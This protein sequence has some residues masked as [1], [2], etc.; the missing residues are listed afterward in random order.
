MASNGQR[1]TLEEID[2]KEGLDGLAAKSQCQRD[3]EAADISL[4]GLRLTPT[5]AVQQE[6]SQDPFTGSSK[7]AESPTRLTR[8]ARA[9]RSARRQTLE[10]RVR[11][12]RLHHG[13]A[14]EIS[15]YDVS[16]PASGRLTIY[17]SRPAAADIP[18]ADI[19]AAG[20]DTHADSRRLDTSVSAAA[21]ADDTP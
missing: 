15:D 18:A 13:R 19:H 7:D 14:A 8:Y 16:D 9:R 5:P 12:P 2:N 17:R 11:G 1:Q 3:D 21:A 10:D 20:T 6:V 4:D